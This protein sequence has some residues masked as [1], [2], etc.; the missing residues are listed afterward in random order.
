MLT[1]PHAPNL[2]PVR[3]LLGCVALALA[4]PA[5]TAGAETHPFSVH[6]MVAMERVGD[7]LPSPDG[8]WVVFTRRA[9]DEAA[10]KNSTS[11]SLAAIDG[12]SARR[13]TSARQTADTS[14][15]WSPDSRF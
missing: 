5:A 8:R 15:T 12:S 9:W 6:D 3:L 13:L 10:N 7:P 4:A 14:P 1:G 11:L 2:R